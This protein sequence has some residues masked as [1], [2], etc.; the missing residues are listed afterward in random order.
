M[1]KPYNSAFYADMNVAMVFHFVNCHHVCF[2]V[3][4]GRFSL[5]LFPESPINDPARKQCPTIRLLSITVTQFR[6]MMDK[7]FQSQLSYAV[8][9]LL[10]SFN[11]FRETGISSIFKQS[12]YIVPPVY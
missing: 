2:I 10:L 9:F 7:I 8:G 5:V 6:L 3:I 4:N 12:E 1:E 11:I